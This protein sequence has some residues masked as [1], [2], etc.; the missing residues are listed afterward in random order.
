MTSKKASNNIKVQDFNPEQLL[1]ELKN[2]GK[3]LNLHQGYIELI[4]KKVIKNLN[5]WLEKKTI[6]TKNDI[7]RK[8]VQE[9]QKYHKDL[10]YLYQNRDKMI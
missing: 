2:E 3:I 10:A 4:S 9:L 5:K 8:V 1:S 7:N 6:V